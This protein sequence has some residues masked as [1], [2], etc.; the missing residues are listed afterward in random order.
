MFKPV[1][2]TTRRMDALKLHVSDTDTM[3]DICLMHAYT[4]DYRQT[5]QFLLVFQGWL[6]QQTGVTFPLPNEVSSTVKSWTY[7][8]LRCLGN[9][10]P[11]NTPYPYSPR[12]VNT[13]FIITPKDKARR[14]VLNNVNVINANKSGMTGKCYSTQNRVRNFPE[15]LSN[16]DYEL[17]YHGTSHG[18]ANRRRH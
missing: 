11:R 16:N 9:S 3:L 1:S 15:S 18:S 14:K 10:F 12:N 7:N 5:V 2:Y 13:W 8:I 17:F 6:T 4:S